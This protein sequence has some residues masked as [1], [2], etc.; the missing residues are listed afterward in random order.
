MVI[1]P[2]SP[3]SALAVRAASS[4]TRPSQMVT[5]NP[6]SISTSATAPCARAMF[7]ATRRMPSWAV[8]RARSERVRKVPHSRASS[9][10]MLSVVP[11]SMRAMVIT[12]GSATPTRRVTIT[13]SAMTIS[14]A[15]GM[16]SSAS[17]GMEAWPPLPRT[18]TRI[19]SD[20][21]SSGPV[22]P[23]N[24]PLGM[25]GEMC[26]A[27]AASG[28][29]SIRP[30]SSMKRAPWW[31]SSPGWNMNITVPDSVSRFSHRARAAPASIAT[32]VSWP[33]A[34]IAPRV[35]DEYSSSVSSTSGSASMSPRS[36][37][38]RPLAGPRRMAR[39]PLVDGPSRISSG[40]PA[41]AAFTLAVVRGRSSPSSG[42]AWI[43][44]RRVMASGS[45]ASPAAIQIFLSRVTAFIEVL[46]QN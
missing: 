17:C 2:C 14:Q 16:G 20:E 36:S 22:R 43:A 1:Q 27:K 44:R 45:R 15:I 19:L 33:Q 41:S 31:P 18:L 10:M 40:R 34:C 8:A 42:S 29:G 3:Y 39:M 24:T 21:A 38:V 5:G 30:S 46:L 28:I 9:G 7:S 4:V 32:W 23:A 13:C 26:R 37:T 11:A 6:C 12:A 35:C 25:L